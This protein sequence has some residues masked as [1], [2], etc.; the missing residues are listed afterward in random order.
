MAPSAIAQPF[1]TPRWSLLHR[2]FFRFLF[3]YFL[4]Y[5]LP[6]TGRV[7]LLSDIPGASWIA[8]KYVSLWHALCPWAG[9]HFFH[10]S[11]RP[12]T[13][14]PTGSGDT[15]LDYIENLLF[16]FVA[17]AAALVWSA[18]D[19]KR[20]DYRGLEAW[21]R[22]LIRY[23][24]AFTL[25]GYGFA[26][27]F[28]LQFRTPGLLR[29]IEPYGDFSPM[30][31]L[32]WFM[33]ASAPYTI[34]AGFSEVIGG[35]LLLF[36]R[37]TTLGSLIAFGVLLNVVMLNFCYDV[38][39][40]LYST[41][42][43]LMAL[44]LASPDLQRLFD[45]F[46]RN[47]PTVPTDLAGPRFSRRSVR[48]GAVVFQV[49]FVGYALYGNIVGGWRSYQTTRVNPPR[50]AVYGIW[51]VETFMRN[52]HEVPPLVTDTTRWRRFIADFP[53]SIAV[54]TMDDKLKSY[55]AEYSKTG[56]TLTLFEGSD[57]S[58][59]YKLVYTRLNPDHL[60]L[61]GTIGGDTLSLGLR[62]IDSSKFLLLSRGFHWINEVPLNR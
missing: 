12:V 47:R 35:L 36:R 5:A 23:T 24:L 58:K 52:G 30:G 9:S 61:D 60:T 15:T 54:K 38:P 49:L 26:K 59:G 20:R 29:L 28:P 37:T 51:E 21:L 13:Y 16:L 48:V 27:V 43:L 50:P 11:G 44:Y 42:L 32:W 41:N 6:S 8:E 55:R 22:L 46:V 31:A 1:E 45:F 40:K 53:G 62:R 3:S 17:L 2:A 10:L 33:G 4:L 39:V 34:F 19:R 14:V 25:F 57:G 18:L 56:T 7:S